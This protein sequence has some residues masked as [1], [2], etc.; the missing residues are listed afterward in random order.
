MIPCKLCFSAR[1]MQNFL[2]FSKKYKLSMKYVN[3][4]F[5][6]I[7]NKDFIP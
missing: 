6:N 2:G 1:F 3:G 4:K 5:F 7:K